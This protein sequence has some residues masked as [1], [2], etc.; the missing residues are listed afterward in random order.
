MDMREF[1]ARLVM[2]RK[3]LNL[4][5]TQLAA[6]AGVDYM[7][8]SRWEKGQS[9]PSLERAI[10]LARALRVSLDLLTTGTEPGPPPTPP[11]P[12]VFQN[13]ELLQRMHQLDELPRDRQEV[14]LR[15]LDTVITGHALEDLATRL[16][17]T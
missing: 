1:G 17:R 12:P 15:V 4:T 13:Q 2:L 7:T 9:L 16:R 6:H 3:R 10:I 5:T 14:A 8:I 11:P